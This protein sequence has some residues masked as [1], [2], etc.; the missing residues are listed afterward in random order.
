MSILETGARILSQKLGVD[1]NPETIQP[2]LAQLLGDGSGNIDIAG[3]VSRLS[4]EGG[5]GSAVQSWLGEGGNDGIS[6]ST[7]TDVL[8]SERIKTFAEQLGIGS[9]TAAEGLSEAVPEMVDQASSGGSLLDSVG[10]V[11]G[12]FGAAKGMFSQ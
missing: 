4:A 10:G 5:L 3:L 12:L 8:G 7:I 9:D 1:I 11:G 6:A 2:A